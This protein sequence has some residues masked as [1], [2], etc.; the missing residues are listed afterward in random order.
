M[1]KNCAVCTRHGLYTQKACEKR[2]SQ[3]LGY[4]DGR[5]TEHGNEALDRGLCA[6]CISRGPVERLQHWVCLPKQAITLAEIGEK[7]GIFALKT[8]ADSCFIPEMQMGILFK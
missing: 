7:R 8:S 1:K 3:V 2:T 6:A 5:D 4:V